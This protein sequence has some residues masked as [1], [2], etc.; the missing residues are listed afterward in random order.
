M[1]GMLGIKQNVYSTFGD[2]SSGF[3]LLSFILV[4]RIYLNPQFKATS[5]WTTP[6]FIQCSRCSSRI[7]SIFLLIPCVLPFNFGREVFFCS[8]TN[9]SIFFTILPA[10][11]K[12]GSPPCKQGL[13]LYILFSADHAQQL[14]LVSV[15]TI[16]KVMIVMHNKASASNCGKIGC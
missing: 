5:R 4:R 9:A 7:P 10:L 1:L 15:L 12:I 16:Y 8:P 11:S 13:K 6:T 14:G 3:Q 2:V